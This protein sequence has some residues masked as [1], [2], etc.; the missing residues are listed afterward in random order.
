MVKKESDVETEVPYKRF[1][2][3]DLSLVVLYCRGRCSSD[4][5]VI[6]G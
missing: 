3:T 4:V 6:S 2:L 5:V 1:R